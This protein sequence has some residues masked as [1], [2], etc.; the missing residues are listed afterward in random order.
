MYR[1]CWV[2]AGTRYDLSRRVSVGRATDNK[3]GRDCTIEIAREYM[4]SEASAKAVASA[5]TRQEEIAERIEGILWQA[6]KGGQMMIPNDDPLWTPPGWTRMASKSHETLISAVT[7]IYQ[8]FHLDRTETWDDAKMLASMRA[9]ISELGWR[10]AKALCLFGWTFAST[11]SLRNI[12]S[13]LRPSGLMVGDLDHVK[14]VDGLL[15]RLQADPLIFIPA[16]SP[17]ETGIKI[18]IRIEDHVAKDPRLYERCFETFERYMKRHYPEASVN[19]NKQAKAV[20]QL[21]FFLHDAGVFCREDSYVL[22]PDDAG[23]DQNAPEKCKQHAAAGEKRPS[24]VKSDH[25]RP[26][27][28]TE[29]KEDADYAADEATLRSAL[30][31][32]PADDRAVWFRVL[33]ALRWW[34]WTVDEEELAFEIADTW[35]QS[36][37][38]YNEADQRK[39]WESLKRET[40]GGEK[41]EKGN[42]KIITT[43]TLFRLAKEHGWKPPQQTK[44]G[45]ITL[46]MFGGPVR[47][48]RFCEKLFDHLAKTERV[49]LRTGQVFRLS[50]PEREPILIPVKAAGMITLAEEFVRIA[51]A[52]AEE[53]VH[54]HLLDENQARIILD[55]GGAVSATANPGDCQR[56]SSLPDGGWCGIG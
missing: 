9:K 24:G 47:A 3:I 8:Q 11:F 21:C 14:D 53:R 2:I 37:T 36:S 35:S 33:C 12:S 15:A 22:L 34:G 30:D 5:R 52:D 6:S 50:N 56:P 18:I 38:K 31:C 42:P 54:Y 13:L 28:A 10:M 26:G 7:A 19:V 17:S 45:R 20:S 1:G 55:S 39:T 41:D 46:A 32:I 16:R 27:R 40:E 4:R 23:P 25:A 29:K 51:Y 44:D 49:F 48:T 43:G